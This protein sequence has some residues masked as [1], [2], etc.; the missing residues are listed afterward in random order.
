MIREYVAKPWAQRSLGAARIE[1][2][3]QALS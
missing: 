1:A 2:I 3:R